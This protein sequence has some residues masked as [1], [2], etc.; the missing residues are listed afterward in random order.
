MLGGDE[1]ALVRDREQGPA[2]G[3]LDQLQGGAGRVGGRREERLG[4]TGAGLALDQ[5]GQDQVGPLPSLLAVGDVEA[6]HPAAGHRVGHDPATEAWDV[7]GFDARFPPP[8]CSGRGVEPDHRRLLVEALDH[9]HLAIGPDDG[10][11]RRGAL[12]PL[13]AGRPVDG[14]EGERPAVLAGR[15]V[16]G[17]HD[18][19][20]QGELDVGDRAEVE[21]P[22]WLARR[23]VEAGQVRPDLGR[24]V[25]RGGQHDHAR[26]GRQRPAPLGVTGERSRPLL[27]ARQAIEGPSGGRLAVALAA[28]PDQE[29][30]VHHHAREGVGRRVDR[31]AEPLRACR[32]VDGEDQGVGPRRHDR[33]RR[34]RRGGGPGRPRRRGRRRGRRHGRRDRGRARG[35]RGR[36]VGRGAARTVASARGHRGDHDADERRALHGHP[37]SPDRPEQCS[38]RACCDRE[39]V[40]RRWYETSPVASGQHG[41]VTTGWSPRAGD[42]GH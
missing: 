38:P 35:R 7:G 16:G 6:R 8:L 23:G 20:V 30:V 41:L 10:D 27:L 18:G 24:L 42:P 15:L 29:V 26:I 21:L 2:V 32:G 3:Q 1:A 28:E 40:A 17:Q 33:R 36:G 22:P 5:L 12:P 25:C 9:H 13:L 37:R 14:H 34:R 4:S 39:L 19:L 31:Q 11:T